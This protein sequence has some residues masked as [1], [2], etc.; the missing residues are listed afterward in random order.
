ME[1]GKPNSAI[2]PTVSYVCMHEFE[3][4]EIIE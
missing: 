3:T 4:A 2:G 1:G